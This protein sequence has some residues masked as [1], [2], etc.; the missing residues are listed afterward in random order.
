MADRETLSTGLPEFAPY[1]LSFTGP[2]WIDAEG[3]GT[4]HS[5]RDYAKKI[6]AA[7]NK[8]LPRAE[9]ALKTVDESVIHQ[10]AS[11]LQADSVDLD[12]LEGATSG[13]VLRAIQ[14]Y[15]SA[16]RSSETARMDETE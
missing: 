15:R 11:L 1:V 8:D 6:V 12:A 3:D 16:R 14:G 9:E 5:P 10:T 7:A 4:Y 2:I 13:R